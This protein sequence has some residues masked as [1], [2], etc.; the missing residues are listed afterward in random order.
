MLRTDLFK[1]VDRVDTRFIAV[2]DTLTKPGL[3]LTIGE[4]DV[5][6]CNK[7]RLGVG[8]HFVVLDTGTIQLGRNIETCGSHTKGQDDLSVSIGVVGGL[9]E[10]GKRAL[11]R[12]DE[13]WQAIDD[14]VQFLQDRYPSATISDNPTP[15]YPTP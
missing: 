12:T 7:G 4:L 14:L 11:T 5:L 2:R 3:E 1:T 13:Q 8:W 6:H 9:D 15:N 10:E